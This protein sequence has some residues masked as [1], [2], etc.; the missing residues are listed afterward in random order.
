MHR[1]QTVALVQP[2]LQLIGVEFK[3][4]SSRF[5]WSPLGRVFPCSQRLTVCCPTVRVPLTR[6][7]PAPLRALLLD[8]I[9]NLH[10]FY[11]HTQGVRVIT[12]VYGSL[13][14]SS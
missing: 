1:S 6:P 7:R 5:T 2:D 10:G 3:S 12:R 11:Y 9:G 4:S 13:Y 8:A 14:R